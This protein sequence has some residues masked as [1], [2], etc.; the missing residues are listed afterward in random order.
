MDIAATR[1]TGNAPADAISLLPAASPGPAPTVFEKHRPASAPSS[2][3]DDG[4]VS[5]NEASPPGHRLATEPALRPAQQAASLSVARRLALEEVASTVSPHWLREDLAGGALPTQP[6]PPLLRAAFDHQECI[7]I[8]VPM[9][10]Q[11]SRLAAGLPGWLAQLPARH[12]HLECSQPEY[13]G[14]MAGV[15]ARVRW[16]RDVVERAREH[17]DSSRLVLDVSYAFQMGSS[18]YPDQQA[19]CRLAVGKLWTSLGDSPQIRTLSLTGLFWSL[20][21]VLLAML[22]GQSRVER[23][24]F[25]HCVMLHTTAVLLAQVLEKQDSLVSLDLLGLDLSCAPAGAQSLWE[26]ISRCGPALR[27]L[28]LRGCDKDSNEQARAHLQAWKQHRP[29]LEVLLD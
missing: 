27:L 21:T 8:R 14:G 13:G 3:G 7:G 22:Q 11:F 5:E 19:S 2:P 12:L 10:P 4:R 25:H 24:E 26:G 17:P 28:D 16:I 15:E 9:W 29:Q 6:P 23:M 1:I 20:D 18:L